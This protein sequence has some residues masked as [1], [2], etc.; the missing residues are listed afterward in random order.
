M[1]G[2]E[3]SRGDDGGEISRMQIRD[4][5]TQKRVR[6]FVVNSLSTLKWQQ[7]VIVTKW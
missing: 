4:L 5:Q 1:S 7:Q 3:V 6:F 2:G